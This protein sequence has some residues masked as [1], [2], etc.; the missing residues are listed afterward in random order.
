MM[1]AFEK[2]DGET[3]TP[4]DADRFLSTIYVHTVSS[5]Y[6]RPSTHKHVQAH[7]QRTCK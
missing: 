5:Q 4:S 6:Y 1:H 2:C 7:A 3:E